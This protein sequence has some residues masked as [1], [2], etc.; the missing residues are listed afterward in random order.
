MLERREDQWRLGEL[1]F[2]LWWEGY[3][4]D[5]CWIRATVE[6]LIDEQ[7]AEVRRLQAEHPDPFDAA[8]ALVVRARTEGLGRSSFFRLL[9]YRLGGNDEYVWSVVHTLFLLAFG[10]EPQWD[11]EFPDPAGDEPSPREL[12]ERAFA[13]PR[14]MKDPIYAAAPWLSDKPDVAAL[15]LRLRD[16]GVF[17]LKNPGELA[18]RATDAELEQARHDA[19]LLCDSLTDIAEAAEAVFGRDI[20]GLGILA[21]MRRDSGY[22]SR[23]YIVRYCLVLRQIVPAGSIERIAAVAPPAAALARGVVEL[24][25]TFPK[26]RGYLKYD[27]RARLSNLPKEVQSTVTTLVASFINSRPALRAALERSN[28]SSDTGHPS[29]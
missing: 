2:Q 9:R 15:L 22:G 18:S 28:R 14:A 20:A 3:D 27:A 1:R 26:L 8:D 12:V 4:I 21:A 25:R 29:E 6:T 17:D 13:I 24:Q 19:V 7:I 11:P 10:G 16:A 5:E 23:A